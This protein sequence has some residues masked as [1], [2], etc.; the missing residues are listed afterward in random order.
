MIRE[1]A[2]RTLS[3]ID[4]PVE[5]ERPKVARVEVR[6]LEAARVGGRPGQAVLELQTGEVCAAS[7]PE[8]GTV[9][10]FLGLGL[11]YGWVQIK[12]PIDEVLDVERRTKHLEVGGQLDRSRRQAAD[13]TPQRQLGFLGRLLR[14][15]RSHLA[16]V[17]AQLGLQDV[18]LGN[19]AD[20]VPRF[21]E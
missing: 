6:E 15:E 4:L 13:Q 10:S 8:A 19:L 1:W 2:V 17:Q 18:G 12:R 21:R 11:T 7:D 5:R 3:S 14:L 16:L 20:V 9:G